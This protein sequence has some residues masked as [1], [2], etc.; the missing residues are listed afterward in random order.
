MLLDLPKHVLFWHSWGLPKTCRPKL[1]FFSSHE[2]KLLPK[3]ASPIRDK[4]SQ[5]IAYW[6]KTYIR[7]NPKKEK[8]VSVWIFS[9]P[10]QICTLS[11]NSYRLRRRLRSAKHDN[12][13]DMG[14]G[15]LANRLAD[16]GHI[17][18]YHDP[19]CRRRYYHPRTAGWA[20]SIDCCVLWCVLF[21]R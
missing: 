9:H 13:R 12:Q 20:I 2:P 14:Y 11:T 5:N 7:R 3:L 18:F 17:D 6:Y 4:N 15:P 1:V 16:L 19:Q 10:V 8:Y 21:A